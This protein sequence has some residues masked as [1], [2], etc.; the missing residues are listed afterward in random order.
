MTKDGQLNESSTKREIENRFSNAR[1]VMDDLCRAYY[2]MSGST[3]RREAKTMRPR[4]RARPPI[5]TDAEILAYDN[6]PVDVAAR[7]LD[8][9]EQTVRLALREGRA[10]FGIAVKDKALT[11]KISPGGLVKYKREGVP[12]FDYETIVHMIRTAVASTIQSEMSDFKTE[13]F[14]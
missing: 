6:V 5:P 14:N 13:L 4:T 10:T 8:W 9:P 7:Y 2:G 11:Y 1:R 12:C 3:G